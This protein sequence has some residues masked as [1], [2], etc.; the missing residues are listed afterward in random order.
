[1]LSHNAYFLDISI[2]SLWIIVCSITGH[3]FL[4]TLVILLCVGGNISPYSRTM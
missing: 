1:M 4:K 3:V 2:S